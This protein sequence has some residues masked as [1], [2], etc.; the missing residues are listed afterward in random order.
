MANSAKKLLRG[1]CTLLC[2]V[3]PTEPLIAS[4]ITVTS[5]ADSGTGSFRSAVAAANSGDT[6]AFGVGSYATITLAS[7]VS[8]AKNITIDGNGSP[9]LRI[10]GPGGTAHTLYFSGAAT[11]AAVDNLY[12]TGSG[13]S[14]IWIANSTV[15]INNVRFVYNRGDAG[16]INNDR[17][18]VTIS[19]SY[20]S[21]NQGAHGGAIET[22]GPAT[23]SSSIFLF[24]SSTSGEGAIR[25]NDTTLNVTNS[26]FTGNQSA[27]NFHMIDVTGGTATIASSTLQADSAL[28]VK[29]AASVTVVNSIVTC[30]GTVIDGGYNLSDDNSCALTASTSKNNTTAFFSSYLGFPSLPEPGNPVIDAGIGAPNCPAQDVRGVARPQGAAC[31]IGAVEARQFTISANVSTGGQ[32]SSIDF[33]IPATSNGIVSCRSASGTCSAVYVEGGLIRF[34]EAPDAGYHLASMSG[35]GGSLTGNEFMTK[36]I[37]ASCS[38]TVSFAPNTHAISGMLGVLAGNGFVLHLDYGSG[39]EDLP[40]AAGS[41]NFQFLSAVPFGSTYAVT[42]GNQPQEPNQTCAVTNDAGGTMPNANVSDVAVTCTTNTYTIG[43]TINGATGPVQLELDGTNPTSTQTQSFS[44]PAFNFATPL[45][46]GSDWNI[47]ITGQ[48]SGQSCTILNNSGTDLEFDISEFGAV[49]ECTTLQPLL[50]LSVDDSQSYAQYG[51]SLSYVVTLDNI[52]TAASGAVAVSA[53]TSA[54]LDMTDAVWSCV[55]SGGAICSVHGM[56]VFNDNASVPVG[57]KATWVISVPVFDAIADPT[58]Q[59]TISA[60]GTSSASDTDT[61]VIFRDG[62]SSGDDGQ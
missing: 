61:L 42:I 13:D 38:L 6:I 34:T 53:A 51:K 46:A 14:A 49:V 15:S 23:V 1:T 36:A 37:T 33:A 35:C 57:G 19:N 45:S 54:G 26:F 29:S 60:P 16:A 56:G 30:S 41:T 21:H 55:P 11:T 7:T 20:F 18:N 28:G 17:G 50:G 9:D 8:I 47:S 22:F 52:G 5:T 58:V 62:F 3:L 43:G 40:V 48:P 12:F 27:S 31:D 2:A 32:M 59:I 4:T 10:V 39:S 44:T 24:N 25:A